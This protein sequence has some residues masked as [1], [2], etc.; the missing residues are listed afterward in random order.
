MASAF[1]AIQLLDEEVSRDAGREPEEVTQPLAKGVESSRRPPR[2]IPLRPVARLPSLEGE[3]GWPLHVVV[4]GP[5]LITL[6]AL[7]TRRE[8]AGGARP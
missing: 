8:T 1:D 2:P 7:D 6:V 5:P 4:A 3:A